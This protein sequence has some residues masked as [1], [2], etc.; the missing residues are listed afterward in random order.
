ML[1]I[2]QSWFKNYS[3]FTETLNLCQYQ[4]ENIGCK[5]GQKIKMDII[6]QGL[7]EHTSCHIIENPNCSSDFTHI[8]K[9]CDGN[10]SCTL[11]GMDFSTSICKV[12][13]RYI[14][15]SYKCLERCKYIIFRSGK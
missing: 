11:T 7:L 9:K 15:V 8:R 2:Q 14:G 5:A 6:A 3:I 4:S 13:P 10:T 12:Y 1:H